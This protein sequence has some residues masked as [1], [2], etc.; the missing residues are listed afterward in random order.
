MSASTIPLDAWSHV[1]WVADGDTW[2]LYING[3][4]DAES[5]GHADHLLDA[6]SADGF[7]I[8][9]TRSNNPNGAS[10][11]YFAEAR[12]WKCARTGEEI[13]AA[14]GT[15]I[16]DAWRKEDLIGYWP[17]NDGPADYAL[18]GNKARNYACPDAKKY[19]PSGAEPFTCSYARGSRVGWVASALPL[20]ELRIA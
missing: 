2:R 6:S 9:N 4:L 7:V 16:A 8:G 1:A 3:N 10:K 11:A 12:V 5:T 18:N 14:K 15:R 17:L 13:N 19:T 20:R